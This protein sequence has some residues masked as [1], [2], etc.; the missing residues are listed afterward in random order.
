MMDEIVKEVAGKIKAYNLAL[1][2]KIEVPKPE[3]SQAFVQVKKQLQ[4][5]LKMHVPLK[6]FRMT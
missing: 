2:A 3:I 5:E 4:N 1:E 6:F